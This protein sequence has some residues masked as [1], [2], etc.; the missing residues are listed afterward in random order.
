MDY[1][2]PLPA[3]LL[4]DDWSSKRSSVVLQDQVVILPIK[5]KNVGNIQFKIKCIWSTFETEG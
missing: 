5:S 3:L 2:T 1:H 4:V